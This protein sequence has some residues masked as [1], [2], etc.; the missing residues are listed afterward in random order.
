MW[1]HC[2]PLWTPCGHFWNV[3]EMYIYG[4]L[5]A[6][7]S[8]I[9]LLVLL[10]LQ[11]HWSDKLVKEVQF[12]QML[13]PLSKH[14]LARLSQLNCGWDIFGMGCDLTLFVNPDGKILKLNFW[15]YNW[16]VIFSNS[17]GAVPNLIA[18][19]RVLMSPPP[20]VILTDETALTEW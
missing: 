2:W 12:K 5:I 9:F 8:M 1:H 19:I 11:L 3:P 13:W 4:E 20:M 10:Q 6:K 17:Y 7:P 16:I 14:L 15:L 18:A